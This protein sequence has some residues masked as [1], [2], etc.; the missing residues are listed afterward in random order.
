VTK[1]SLELSLVRVQTLRNM[2]DNVRASIK[3]GNLWAVRRHDD[4]NCGRRGCYQFKMKGRMTETKKQRLSQ[5][6]RPKLAQW[7]PAKMAA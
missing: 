3:S 1:E 5:L 2:S 7:E 6:S 4:V